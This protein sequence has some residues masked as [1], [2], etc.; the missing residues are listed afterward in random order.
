MVTAV[1]A[2]P[3]RF[4]KYNIEFIK[5]LEF[6]SRALQGL[7]LK[8]AKLPNYWTKDDIEKWI[9]KEWNRHHAKH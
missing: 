2:G 1:H 8:G 7:T 5:L 4:M 3:R 6:R 9:L